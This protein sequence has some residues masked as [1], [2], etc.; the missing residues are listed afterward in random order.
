[1]DHLPSEIIERIFHHLDAFDAHRFGLTQR[2]AFEV[3]R[4]ERELGVVSQYHRW[5]D[6]VEKR[7]IALMKEWSKVYAEDRDSRY[8]PSLQHEIQHCCD[9]VCWGDQ[10][11]ELITGTYYDR[12]DL[13][14]EGFAM[15]MV[16]AYESTLV[17]FSGLYRCTVCGLRNVE[18][19][20]TWNGD[21]WGYGIHDQHSQPKCVE[22]M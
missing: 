3:I 10:L 22:C 16:E 13:D 21:A 8:A 18:Q 12:N 5:F 1:M 20:M 19:F 7:M 11:W 9:S 4:F 15:N 14:L 2:R 6:D 17:N